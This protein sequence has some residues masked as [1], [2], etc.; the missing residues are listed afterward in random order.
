MELELK[1]LAPYLPYKLKLQIAGEYI[2]DNEHEGL[3]TWR[4]AGIVDNDILV[5]KQGYISNIENEIEDCFPILRPLSDL[6]K[7]IQIGE[8]YTS[9]R[10]HLKRIYP[11]ES[12]SS[13]T[14]TWTWRSF[15]WLLERHFD[16]FG[17]IPGG[18]AI[19]INTL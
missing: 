17:L 7:E 8:F 3:R 4:M 15:E 18:L 2:D 16:V 12:I 1:H 10:L 11:S 19:D 14:A 13:N 9:F 6:N 5:H